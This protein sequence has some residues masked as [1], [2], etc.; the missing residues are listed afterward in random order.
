M[1]SC[2]IVAVIGE[3]NAGKSTLVNALTGGKVSIVTPKV[4]TTRFNVRGVCIHKDAQV[5]LV[6]TPG[7]FDAGK[8]FEKAM[9]QAAWAGI[10]DADV[11]LLLIDA[12]AKLSDG[13]LRILDRLKKIQPK[14]L[15]VCINKTDKV[16][17]EALLTLAK[18]IGKRLEGSDAV[19]RIFM[20]SALKG[21]GVD[22]LKAELA[23]CMPKGA[24]LYPEDQLTD[25][26]M[27]LLAAEITREK[28][29]LKLSQELPYAI[30]VETEQWEEK[31]NGV[32][33]SQCI[34]VQKEGQKKI[35]IGKGGDT[36]KRI[37]MSARKELEAM[38]EKPV[39]LALFV[40]VKPGWKED[41]ESYR[42]PGLEYRK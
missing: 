31:K 27:R 13:T 26:P 22:Y 9:V 25:I 28:L 42:L 4:Q 16:E 41:R 24:W 2:G 1:T 37:G 7:I 11:V 6:D 5:V 15:C 3:P 30:A 40:K 10:G 21:S 33:I 20:A 32:R 39:H 12:K 35:V 38:V 19:G 17:K 8:P 18:D 29:F 23:R 36:I 34:L 14:N